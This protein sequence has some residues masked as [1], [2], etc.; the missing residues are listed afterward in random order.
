MFVPRLDYFALEQRVNQDF[1]RARRRA[2]WHRVLS[3][4]KRRST[5]LLNFDAIY[6]CIPFAGQRDSGVQTVALAD[7]VGS[8]GRSTDFDDTF[9]PVKNHNQDRWKSVAFA[10]HTGKPLPPIEVVKIGRFYFVKDGNHRVSVAR[11][12]GEEY[13][14]ANVVEMTTTP[15]TRVTA[16]VN[17]VKSA[18]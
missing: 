15:D 3:F 13:I 5:A 7:I 12:N 9:M 18:G 1:E 14:E 8:M 2:F 17:A 11:I 16:V 10:R 6:G 4:I